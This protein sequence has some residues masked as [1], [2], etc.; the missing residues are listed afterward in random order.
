MQKPLLITANLK[1][2]D[3]GPRLLAS[4]VRL[5]DDAIAEWHG[6]VAILVAGR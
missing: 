6:G 5:L 4:R 2:E 3:N 1:I